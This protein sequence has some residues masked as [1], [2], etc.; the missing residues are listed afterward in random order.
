MT[1]N[2]RYRI[3]FFL[4]TIFCIITL[5]L[6][7]KNYNLFD[8][9]VLVEFN[10]GK[11]IEESA[12]AFNIEPSYLK[13]LCFLESSGKKPAG[14]RFEKKVFEE[15]K[16]L[17]ASNRGFYN[18]LSSS[19]IK[20]ASDDALKNLAT[21]WGPFQ[22]MGYQCLLIGVKV[23]DIRGDSTVYY[24]VKWIKQT[25]GD[26]LNKGKYADAFHIHNRGIPVPSN[27]QFRT[28]NKKY[29]PNGLSLMKYFDQ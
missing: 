14:K 13:A 24:S 8:S 25:Y 20:N 28:Y 11:E 15:L 7:F 5:L 4:I 12:D 10:Y 22:L 1:K 23:Q 29:V 2:K 3:S 27:G 17:R 6:V 18:G 9:K 16:K 21:S 19:M 26:Y